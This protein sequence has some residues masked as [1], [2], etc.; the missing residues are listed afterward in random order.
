MR[1]E[2]QGLWLQEQVREALSRAESL[3]I[4]GSGSKAFLQTAPEAPC[5]RLSVEGHCGLVEYEP[6]ELVITVR[7]GTPLARVEALLAEHGQMLAFEPPAFGPTAT[8]GG[9]LAC[10]LSGPRRPYT[11]SARDF[12]LGCRM[13]NGQGQ[14]LSFGGRVIKN[15]AGFDVSRLMVGSAGTLG[16]LLELSLKVLPRPECELTLSFDGTAEEALLRMSEWGRAAWPLSALVHD[17]E[18][19]LMRLSGSE[20]AL[21]AAHRQLGG[22]AL[23]MASTFWHDWREQRLAWFQDETPL[24]RLSLAPT[25]PLPALPGTWRID[26]GGS[27]R[28]FKTHASPEDIFLAMARV[29]GHA[30]HFRGGSV[31]LR[32]QPLPVPLQA[33]QQRLRTAFDPYGVFRVNPALNQILT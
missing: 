19:I 30:R 5:R 12:V 21:Q 20:R 27:L 31:S 10:G 16:V 4:S 33:L 9:T 14:R 1:T 18:R 11:G 15:V 13:L 3:Y 26:W 7:A 2:D 6:G 28:W 23:P 17:G 8:I 29:G 24:W 32:H 22:E 25:C